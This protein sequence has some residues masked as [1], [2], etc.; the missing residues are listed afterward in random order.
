MSDGNSEKKKT[1]RWTVSRKEILEGKMRQFKCYFHL[2]I[3]QEVF[4]KGNRHKNSSSQNMQRN[5]E[6]NLVYFS[7]KGNLW[8]EKTYKYL[9]VCKSFKRHIK[10]LCKYLCRI[11]VNKFLVIKYFRVCKR[12]K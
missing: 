5:S 4:S 8:D 11:P 10:L 7:S 6:S 3:F 1:H 9:L 12:M 2:I